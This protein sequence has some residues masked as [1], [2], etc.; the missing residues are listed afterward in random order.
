VSTE[1]RS[2]T[3]SLPRVPEH[4]HS[5]WYYFGGLALFLL[6]MMVVSGML[7]SMYYEPSSAPATTLDGTPL[8]V[9][10]VTKDVTMGDRHYSRDDVIILPLDTGTGR[11]IAP[12]PLAGSVETLKRKMLIDSIPPLR[13]SVAWA[14][15]EGTIMHDVE[16][17]SLIRSIHVYSAN[18]LMAAVII[19][20]FSVFF[21]RAY[22][23]RKGLWLTGLTLLALLLGSAFTGHILPWTTFSFFSARIGA[24]LSDAGIPWIGPALASMLRGGAD[25]GPAT[26]TRVYAMHTI[27]LPLA[28][29]AF[30]ATHLLLV[31]YFGLTN[32]TGMK[33]KGGMLVAGALGGG[34][35]LALI[36][37]ALA[38]DRFETGS[39]AVMVPL[40]VLPVV[41]A[42]MLS[43]MARSPMITGKPAGTVEAP[44][45]A[46][47]PA[48]EAPS[49]VSRFIDRNLL[50]WT[51]ALGIVIT[52]A[53]T[54]PWTGAEIGRVPLELRMPTESV[55]TMHPHWYFMPIYQIL[56]VLPASI[57]VLIAL[58]VAGIWALVPWLDRSGERRNPA[59]TALGIALILAL[60]GLTAWG[61]VSIVGIRAWGA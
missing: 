7:L 2:L 28:L 48:G 14:S 44:V 58:V 21:M 25:I 4:R 29:L 9:G 13:P 19:H 23:R 36:V 8:G 38:A 47:E 17:G 59:L 16:F 5:L 60:A 12:G 34:A 46:V 10:R 20:M 22:R 26:L 61:Y 40:A 27:A 52:L 1:N 51:I 15:V 18:L 50:C 45:A 57:T 41:A 54:A 3:I 42:Y 32:G 39:V 56:Q 30:T 49:H 33:R 35:L 11:V 37:Y 6:A 55:A 53:V 24:S 31:G 43:A